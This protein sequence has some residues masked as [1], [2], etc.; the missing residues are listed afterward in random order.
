MYNLVILFSYGFIS[1]LIYSSVLL[2]S[3]YYH[4][5]ILQ[6]EKTDIILSEV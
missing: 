2:V 3:N 6:I 5:N 1:G 4:D